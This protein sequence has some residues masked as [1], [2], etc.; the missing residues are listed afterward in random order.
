[1]LYDILSVI[2]AAATDLLTGYTLQSRKVQT[3]H[4]DV[5]RMPGRHAPQICESRMVLVDRRQTGQA[6][7]V[8]P[9]LGILGATLFMP[10]ELHESH[11]PHGCHT[12][13]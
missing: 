2:Q 8:L 9:L 1:M 3:I 4:L 5:Y 10:L 6:A 13:P 7:F 11:G 12:S